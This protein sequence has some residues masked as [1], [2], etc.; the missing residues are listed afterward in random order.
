MLLLLLHIEAV[1]HKV[2]QV[3]LLGV[4]LLEDQFLVQNFI[5]VRLD[6][7]Q[8]FLLAFLLDLR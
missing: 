4:A 1:L 8:V 3:H 2:V 5:G 6:K 7:F